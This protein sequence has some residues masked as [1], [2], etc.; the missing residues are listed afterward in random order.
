MRILLIGAGHAHLEVAKR[1]RA[2]AAAGHRLILIDP[3]D[4]WYSGMATGMLGGAWEAGADRL[5]P[6]PLIEGAGGEFIRDRVTA[7][8]RAACTVTLRGGEALRYDRLS[9]NTGSVVDAPFALGAPNVWPVKPIAGLADFRAA[10]EAGRGAQSVLV[11]GGGAAGC[12]CAA[13]LR[14]LARRKGLELRLTLAAA[15]PRLLPGWPDGAGA[16][17]AGWLEAR[18][19]AVRLNNPVTA[20]EEGAAVL[21]SGERLVFDHALIA[22]GL[23]A[24]PLVGQLGLEADPEGGLLV[25]ETLQAPGD[26]RLFAAGDCAA[27]AGH[28][29][30]K[31]GVFGVRAAPVL[32][33]N[34]LAAAGGR[35]MRRYR[36]RRRWFS[37]LDL[38][39]GAALARHGGLWAMGKPLYRLKRW[40]DERFLARYR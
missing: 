14:A 5:D 39:D 23:K 10:L 9:L 35:S 3:G 8:D 34:L 24:P 4:F 13:N 37:A 31:L 18:G 29:R 27:I 28:P 30:P 17:M 40:L 26:A 2:F 33:D 36:P 22:T 6:A 15:S 1:G 32:H 7:I 16:A 12:E 21:E 38:G 19:V 20:L 11:I 25:G